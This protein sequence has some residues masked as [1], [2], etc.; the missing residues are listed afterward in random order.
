MNEQLFTSEVE[1]LL[2]RHF[3]HRLWSKLHRILDHCEPTIVKTWADSK[4]CQ[5]KPLLKTIVSR[6]ATDPLAIYVL[7]QLS[8]NKALFDIV[9]REDSAILETLCI[10]QLE[11]IS[12]IPAAS[13][14]TAE[15]GSHLG[16]FA[17]WKQSR[18]LHVLPSGV[19][20]PTSY[21][22]MLEA[23]LIG[24][25]SEPITSWRQRVYTFLSEASLET[26]S[27]LSDKTIVTCVH[28]W[29]DLGRSKDQLEG[30]YAAY[31]ASRLQ[32]H[33]QSIW[34][35]AS[36]AGSCLAINPSLR[37][38]IEKCAHLFRADNAMVTVSQAMARVLNAIRDERYWEAEGISTAIML[39]K[40]VLTV[41]MVSPDF[42]WNTTA[43][44]VMCK[45]AQKLATVG[46]RLQLACLSVLGLSDVKSLL[47]ELAQA[48]RIVIRAVTEGHIED[49]GGPGVILQVI[50]RYI[51]PLQMM[52][53]HISIESFLK[54][55]VQF[56]IQQCRP[57]RPTTNNKIKMIKQAS[58]FVDTLRENEYA[59][60]LTTAFLQIVQAIHGLPE[61]WAL[62]WSTPGSP[63]NCCGLVACVHYEEM[64]R[65]KLRN[66]FS[67]LVLTKA[68]A[69]EIQL[70]AQMVEV[71]VQQCSQVARPD[72][73]M[74]CAYQP[75][76]AQQHIPHS[77]LDD[78]VT[79]NNWRD[80]LETS[81][82]RSNASIS[83]L[84]EDIVN[85]LEQNLSD[86]TTENRR[87]NDALQTE[88]QHRAGSDAD[89]ETLRSSNLALE[90][91]LA[92]AVEQA[93]EAQ[94]SLET[95][96][97]ERQQLM[98]ENERNAAADLE[99]VERKH[100]NE[101]LRLESL[102]QSQT[103]ANTALEAQTTWLREQMEEAK[104]DLETEHDRKVQGLQRDFDTKRSELEEQTKTLRSELS[105]RSADIDKLNESLATKDQAM[106]SLQ[107]QY[108]E[109]AN[110]VS[111]LESELSEEKEKSGDLNEKLTEATT[112]NEQ[113]ASELGDREAELEEQT[114][115]AAELEAS[116]SHW[117]QRCA[118]AEKS[119]TEAR[120]REEGIQ[121]LLR[122]AGGGMLGMSKTP[123]SK[124]ALSNRRH[125][126]AVLLSGIV[127]SEDD[128]DY[129]QDEIVELGQ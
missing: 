3:Q 129:F 40:S 68:S 108:K 87:L 90:Q 114:Q 50:D 13:N 20:P 47:P 42:R 38:W 35:D 14:A 61:W 44:S 39:A 17:P 70:P 41:A 110:N 46:P 75:F 84:L 8:A 56:I 80:C 113:L 76:I 98:E 16:P 97:L 15:A 116:A 19:A 36:S 52:Q 81:L 91:Q 104:A 60:Q 74:F 9:A 58:A 2:A 92:E 63:E 117:R 51:E 103:Q 83:S 88:Q 86:A 125:T 66:D 127:N 21:Y 85:Q 128:T 64:L 105:S 59:P 30:I 6:I 23:L 111:S 37:A 34:Q 67:A 94:V 73:D 120:Q 69:N 29:S 82:G 10:K 55:L 49:N 99:H 119:L 32:R 79:A 65:Q 118:A 45:L 89:L 27:N 62:D 126:S 57:H 1:A 22:A 26:L 112:A 12:T 33:Q 123:L 100:A 7:L 71:L 11:H 95:A 72:S 53:P 31:I 24:D 48:I 4:P 96:K 106:A 28:R 107:Q 5:V 115:R 109:T 124:P 25:E 102:L 43:S 54:E 122:G 93:K 77:P 78:P 18:L 101:Q 121:A